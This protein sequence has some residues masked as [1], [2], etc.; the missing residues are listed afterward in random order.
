MPEASDHVAAW[1]ERPGHPGE[2]PQ[3]RGP[4]TVP[5]MGVVLAAGRSERLKAV[6]GGG[7][8]SVPSII[9]TLVTPTYPQ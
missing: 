4:W 8:T 6:A 9:G 2:L 1:A 7:S 5:H 3:Q